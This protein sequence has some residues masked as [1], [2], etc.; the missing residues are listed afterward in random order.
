[1]TTDPQPPA[2]WLGPVLIVA[3]SFIWG[4]NWPAIRVTVQE[5]DPWTFRAVCMVA[6]SAMLFGVSL[7]RRMTLAVPRADILPL[8]ALGLLNV[9]AY[10]LLSAYGLTMVEAGRGAILAF[11]FPLWAVLLGTIFLKETLTRGRLVALANRS[12]PISSAM[13]PR[14]RA[15]ADRKSVV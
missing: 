8:I 11:T 7:A 3:L 1:M 12:G 14:P 15:R 4:I 5:I 6:G 2:R 13:P 10:Q 9:S